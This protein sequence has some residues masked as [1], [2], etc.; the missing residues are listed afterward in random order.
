MA[1]GRRVRLR[2]PLRGPLD[3]LLIPPP[4]DGSV[5]VERTR[6]AGMTDHL[7]LPHTHTFIM[8][9]RE[10]SRQ[11]IHFLQHGRFERGEELVP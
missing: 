7:V 4:Q 5:S 9:S 10:V 11:T 6:L 3:R 8:K 1:T 2:E